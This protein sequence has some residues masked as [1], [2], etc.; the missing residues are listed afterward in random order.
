MVPSSAS[1]IPQSSG[2]A[3][4]LCGGT[5]DTEAPDAEV[6]RFFSLTTGTSCR[7]G[8]ISRLILKA[9]S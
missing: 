5:N 9:L 4:G 8:E 1:L 2:R 6:E 3:T 7:T